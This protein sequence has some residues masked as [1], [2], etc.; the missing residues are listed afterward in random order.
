[1]LNNKKVPN[2]LPL[3]RQT[4]IPHDNNKV[5]DYLCP[6]IS[7]QSINESSKKQTI[8][9]NEYAEV[10]NSNIINIKDNHTKG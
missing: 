8:G 10:V 1:M 4:N 2:M 6:N 3:L 7:S 5:Q 9:I